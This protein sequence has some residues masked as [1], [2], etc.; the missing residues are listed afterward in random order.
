MTTVKNFQLTYGSFFGTDEE[1]V[2]ENGR[3]IYRWGDYVPDNE[4]IIPIDQR[5]WEKF[6]SAIGSVVQDWKRNYHLL[7]CDGL[8]WGVEIECDKLS[9]RS[10]GL[11]HFP[12]H[13]DIFL[14][15][16]HTILRCPG[17]AEGHSQKDYLVTGPVPHYVNRRITQLLRR[18]RLK[19]QDLA[20]CLGYPKDYVR[21]QLKA[22]TTFEVEHFLTIARFLEISLTDLL[23]E[24]DLSPRRGR[25]TVITPNDPL[26]LGNPVKDFKTEL[27]HLTGIDPTRMS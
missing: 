10:S 20:E 12:Q 19:Q 13:Y 5:T 6:L 24:T 3:L 8:T 1:L 9:L 7:V 22:T 16:V 17:F 4:Q 11:H 27:R 14:E 25:P 21:I 18:K 23:Y 15:H 26:G 2:W